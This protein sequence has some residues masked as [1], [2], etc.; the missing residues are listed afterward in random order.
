M[1][2]QTVA[3]WTFFAVGTAAIIAGVSVGVKKTPHK[4]LVMFLCL[5]GLATGGVGAYGPAFLSDYTNFVKVIL[6]LPDASPTAL[7]G[8]LGMIGA[9]EVPPKYAEVGLAVIAT[10]PTDAMEPLLDEAIETAANEQGRVALE[11]AR[12]DVRE[13]DASQTVA[14]MANR[15]DSDAYE[16]FFD[17]LAAGKVPEQFQEVGLACVQARPIRGIDTLLTRADSQATTLEQR[18]QWQ[19][20]QR[21]MADT[22]LQ[23]PERRLEE[24]DIDRAK[25]LELRGRAIVPLRPDRE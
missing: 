1:E 25:L 13:R 6:G 23:L 2:V 5:F 16:R 22:L 24:L 18:R 20:V 4:A 19:H 21:R 9:G 17:R 10:Q 14:A 7:A 12:Q 15:Q 8:F 3:E 11:R